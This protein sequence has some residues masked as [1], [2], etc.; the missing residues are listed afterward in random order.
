VNR[1]WTRLLIAMFAIGTFSATRTS[2]CS[3]VGGPGPKG[4]CGDITLR[5]PSFVGTVIDIE[6]PAQTEWRNPDQGGLSRYRFRVDENLSGFDQK[7]VDIYSGRGFADC[8]Y[9]FRKG[10]SY[11]V[12]PS[13]APGDE[14]LMANICNGTN[15]AANAEALIEL[16]RARRDA[17]NGAEID[18]IL[19]TKQQ[20]HDS[21]F[22]A[23]YNRPLHGVLVELRGVTVGYSAQTD[24]TGTYRF[25]GIPAGTYHFAAKLPPHLELASGSRND[26]SP[27]ITI[28]KGQPCYQKNI[29]ALPTARIRGR[30]IDPQGVPIEDADV[31]LFRRE[32]YK[33][34][35]ADWWTVRS[36]AEGYYEFDHLAPGLY[37]V[38]FNNSDTSDP[39]RPYSRTFYPNAVN[40][41]SAEPITI[42]A[43]EQITGPQE[44]LNADIHIRHS[45]KQ[46]PSPQN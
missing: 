10:E 39:S 44:V 4:T 45:V 33:E 38:V 27:A 29:Y 20:P 19:R 41:E 3:C 15:A 16:L 6:N 14:R 8:S 46:D 17:N 28:A 2:A 43:D 34:S 42:G 1:T 40:F 5:G 26:Q 32:R 24:E 9:H 11:L 18:G 22:Y 23:Y 36:D 31:E 30:V 12:K 21:T 35:Q 37:L 13:T 25:E 7:E